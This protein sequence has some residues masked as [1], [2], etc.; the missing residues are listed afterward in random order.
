MLPALL[1]EVGEI[2][3]FFHDSLHT[4]ANMSWEFEVAWPALRD[5]GLLVSDDVFW[6]SAFRRFARAVGAHGRITRGVGF[7]RKPIGVPR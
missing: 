7:L 2:D 3:L 1:A 4:Y 5:G 6:S